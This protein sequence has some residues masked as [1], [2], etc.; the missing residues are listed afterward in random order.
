MQVTFHGEALDTSGTPVAVGSDFPQF[1]LTTKTGKT[2]TKDEL[3]GKVTLISVVPDINTR[4][5]SIS[6]KKFNQE[7]DKFKQ[8]AF[9][10]V[11]TNTVAQQADWCAAEG[12]AKMEVVSDED[13]DFGKATGLYI[14]A[15]GID[16]RSVWVLD[17]A[18]KVVY[19]ELITE[20][21]NEPNYQAVLDFLTKLA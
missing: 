4:V 5:C 15:K 21:T 19:R 8:I 13:K 1:K 17:Q 14:E 9:Y 2:L 16:A 11:S 6:T 10:T 20:Q 7:V 12:V 18:G 3:A